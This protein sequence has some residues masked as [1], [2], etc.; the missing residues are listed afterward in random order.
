MPN[1]ISPLHLK[2]PRIA[3]SSHSQ[4]PR[5]AIASTTMTLSVIIYCRNVSE[6][7]STL[8]NSALVQEEVTEVVAIDDG[9]TDDTYLKLTVLSR[10]DHRLRVLKHD[11][12]LNH[13]CSA[14]RNLGVLESQGTYATFL[15]ADEHY[16]DERLR[17]ERLRLQL[18]KARRS[19]LVDPPLRSER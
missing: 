4:R 7:V 8:V 9:S 5:T 16:L 12:G 2:R 17:L 19:V 3:A 18:S 14:S 10:Y 1:R 15:D 11:D 6:F 13:G